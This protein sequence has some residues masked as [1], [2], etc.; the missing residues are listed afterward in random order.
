MFRMYNVKK[1]G[2][3]EAPAVGYTVEISVITESIAENV[4]YEGEG[5]EWTNNDMI[6]RCAEIRRMCE[7]KYLRMK[8]VVNEN[9]L[10]KW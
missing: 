8:R 5:N 1:N 3:A 4:A 7:Y 9:R 6:L 2:S 10:M